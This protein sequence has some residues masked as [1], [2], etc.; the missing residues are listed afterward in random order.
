[1]TKAV[2]QTLRESIEKKTATT[3]KTEEIVCGMLWEISIS[4]CDC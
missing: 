3:E 2:S 4:N 1:M